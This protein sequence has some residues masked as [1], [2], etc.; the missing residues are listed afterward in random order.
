[1][2]LGRPPDVDDDEILEALE[3]ATSNGQP[4]AIAGDVADRLPIK[5]QATLRRL[6]ELESAGEV[7]SLE[8]GVGY[9][10]WIPDSEGSHA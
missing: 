4:V 6:Q 3:E 9:V 1:M 10:W 2:T 5:E 8:V 7:E